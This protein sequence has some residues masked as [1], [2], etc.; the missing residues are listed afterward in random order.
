MIS[1]LVV[2]AYYKMRVDSLSHQR[3][4]YDFIVGQRTKDMAAQFLCEITQSGRP[5]EVRED[6]FIV[7][8][9]LLSLVHYRD[10]MSWH[11]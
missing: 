11:Y 6:C 9:R 7:N 10:M 3:T 4:A 1:S 8:G 5:S 2:E